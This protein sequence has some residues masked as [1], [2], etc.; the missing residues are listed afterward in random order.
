VAGAGAG[1]RAADCRP[2]PRLRRRCGAAGGGGLRAELDERQ[3]KIGYKI[4]EAQ[5]QKVPYMLVVG[6]REAAEGTVAVRSRTGGDQGARRSTRSSRAR[7]P[8]EVRAPVTPRG[9]SRQGEAGAPAS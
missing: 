9:A 1:G 2:A 7:D 4:R 6:D 8:D 3:E 5:L